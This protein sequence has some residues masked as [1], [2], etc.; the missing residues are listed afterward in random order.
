MFSLNRVLFGAVTTGCTFYYFWFY[1]GFNYGYANLNLP[2]A[3]KVVYFLGF[4]VLEF[5]FL[6][7][8]AKIWDNFKVAYFNKPV[9]NDDLDPKASLKGRV[10]MPVFPLENFSKEKEFTL[11]VG[12]KHKRDGAPV[13][14]PKYYTI[15]EKGL[16]TGVMVFGST[17]SG[18]TSAVA[19]PFLN[20]MLYYQKSNFRKKMGGLVLD[21][22]GNMCYY[23]EDLLIKY[24]REDD[25]IEIKLELSDF[26][27]KRIS[28]IEKQIVLLSG[29]NDLREV[30]EWGRKKLANLKEEI[31]SI[32]AALIDFENEHM[33][34]NK[35]L[36]NKVNLLKDE[37]R[38]LSIFEERDALDKHY[39]KSICLDPRDLSVE[40]R[41][42]ILKVLE[43]R[44][45]R[46]GRIYKW[47][48][49]YMPHMQAGAL[50]GNIKTAIIN[51]R[52]ESKSDPFW[53][54]SS[55]EL[56][57]L[58][59]RGLRHIMR[60]GYFTFF[61][62]S[63]FITSAHEL[64]DQLEGHL[65]IINQLIKGVE[66]DNI[67]SSWGKSSI[68]KYN[69]LKDELNR[70]DSLID[71]FRS[72]AEF[73]FGVDEEGKTNE[74]HV[75]ELLTYKAKKYAEFEKLEKKLVDEG[76]LKKDLD[77]GYQ[78]NSQD[79]A[80]VYDS[81]LEY[82]ECLERYGSKSV[83]EL[84]V[85]KD[86]LGSITH[87]YNNEWMPLDGEKTQALI[88]KN[89]GI[90]ISFFTEP[91]I[92]KVFC[93]KKE[94]LDFEGF[95]PNVVNQGKLVVMNIPQRQYYTQSYLLGTF[96]KLSYQNDML[97]RIPLSIKD[98]SVNTDRNC[99]LLIDECQNYVSEYDA[100]FCAESREAKSINIYLTQAYSSLV[101]AINEKDTKVLTANLRNKIILNTEDTDTAKLGKTL[102][103]QEWTTRE[104]ISR[105][106]SLNNTKY[107][108]FT[109]DF[110]GDGTN[111]SESKSYEKK[112]EDIFGEDVF[113]LLHLNQAFV[114][115]F[116]KDKVIEPCIVYLIPFY[117]EVWNGGNIT[118]YF[119]RWT[120]E[121]PHI[122]KPA[123]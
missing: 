46:I 72:L 21:A 44:R 22:K 45:N 30:Y 37:L 81:V 25:F 63:Y 9:K 102:A 5:F 18:K 123:E 78:F 119:D 96:L 122:L 86:D 70:V 88:Q 120:V 17:G 56:M 55:E 85:L 91:V 29:G 49:L 32:N 109:S 118:S 65:D 33:V 48:P 116:D 114:K 15:P 59:I 4:Y 95:I 80:S 42:R 121:N 117:N 35:E 103:S 104:R 84:R 87:W 64:V 19:Y 77:G 14:Y 69:N 26:D 36:Q 60:D 93:P 1:E 92:K 10:I 57:R 83:E 100:S 58:T 113:Y 20:Q 52:G 112:K 24:E 40:A 76:I 51:V 105:S 67:E 2:A 12:E 53:D 108:V 54:M 47:N 62:L 39:D 101:K 50:T 71:S 11:I 74:E 111:I 97:Q 106:E 68:R 8:L 23:L 110:H 89:F 31:A 13:K 7:V 75:E 28:A 90:I 79:K 16:H 41:S 98:P 34:S 115:G 82:E 107:N 27:R 99:F 73:D 3:F 61:D 38:V 94:E 66:K 6:L 43:N